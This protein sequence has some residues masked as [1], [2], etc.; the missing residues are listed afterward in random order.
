MR[1]GDLLRSTRNASG[2]K[3]RALARELGISHSYLVAIE[4]NTKPASDRVFKR[5]CKILDIDPKMGEYYRAKVRQTAADR[6]ATDPEF[7][8]MVNDLA[9]RRDYESI[10]KAV[11]MDDE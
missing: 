5:V 4:K 11:R 9:E 2:V 6:L 1:F 10:L 3:L 8:A 7:V